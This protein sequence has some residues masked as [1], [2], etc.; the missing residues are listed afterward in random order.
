[1]P[2]T[3]RHAPPIARVNIT[4]IAPIAYGQTGERAAQGDGAIA[5]QKP[6]RGELLL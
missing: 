4:I 6:L 3:E 2:Y 5:C 1:M